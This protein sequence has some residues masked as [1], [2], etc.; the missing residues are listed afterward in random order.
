MNTIVYANADSLSVFRPRYIDPISALTL[1]LHRS[2]R[3]LK[4]TTANT[5]GITTPRM[6][7]IKP[8]KIIYDLSLLFFHFNVVIVRLNPISI[9]SALCKT[10][11]MKEL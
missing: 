6:N 4:S 5:N 7:S 8:E 9:F 3:L 1:G 2:F 11:L 10:N